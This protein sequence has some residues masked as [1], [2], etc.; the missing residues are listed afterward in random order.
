MDQTD[1][2]CQCVGLNTSVASE[3]ALL[4]PDFRKQLVRSI[5]AAKNKKLQIEVLVT[6]LT[7]M[8]QA[9]LWKQG[10]TK[11][12][13]ELKA[14][15]LDHAGAPYLAECI[16]KAIPTG[17]NITTDDLPGYSWH[18]W[19]EAAQMIWIDGAHKVNWSTSVVYGSGNGY[20]TFAKIL[21]EFSIHCAGEFED[22][23]TAWRTAILRPARNAI[24]NYTVQQIDAEMQKRYKR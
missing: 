16:R 24:E 20:K 15:A 5:E 3:I 1:G 7:P 23:P 22:T 2:T 12:D 4:I 6:V 21:N 19:G 10:R 13:A 11:T 9:A 17:T 14:M 18:Q 8:E